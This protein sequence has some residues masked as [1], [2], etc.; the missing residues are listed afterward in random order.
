MV[1]NLSEAVS[2]NGL[3]ASIV[4]GKFTKDGSKLKVV[5]FVCQNNNNLTSLI[6]APE[7]VSGTFF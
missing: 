1:G 6:G 7:T 3:F 5:N 2:L 4:D